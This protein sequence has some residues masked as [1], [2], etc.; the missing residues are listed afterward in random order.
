MGIQ[1]SGYTD[2]GQETRELIG[3]GNCTVVEDSKFITINVTGG[4]GLVNG[5]NV[6]LS[7]DGD[8][9][10]SLI[11]GDG[12]A[13]GEGDLRLNVNP[14]QFEFGMG[15]LNGIGYWA[16]DLP[17]PEEGEAAVL[18]GLNGDNLPQITLYTSGSEGQTNLWDNNG[19]FTIQPTI[20]VVLDSRLEMNGNDI[21]MNAQGS[22]GASARIHNLAD[23]TYS[24][25]AANKNYVDSNLANYLP[26]SGGTMS[27]NI[28]MQGGRINDT[29]DPSVSSDV[30]T[31]HYVDNVGLIGFNAFVADNTSTG[32]TASDLGIQQADCTSGAKSLTLL[33]ATTCLDK[34]FLFQQLNGNSG[35]FLNVNTFSGAQSLQIPDGTM[36]TNFNFDQDN[37]LQLLHVKSNGSN[38]IL[39]N[40]YKAA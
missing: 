3:T 29:S 19:V 39:V 15:V 20:K 40:Y 10:L 31:K 16:F 35:N 12:L 34:E 30:A 7:V 2:R 36:A 17:S 11:I 22:N 28:D 37:K 23:P 26:L 27:G 38:W 18:A 1:L 13:L 24:H 14:D 5:V 9:I 33:D 6:P 32:L 8:G 25:G 4:S 21:Y